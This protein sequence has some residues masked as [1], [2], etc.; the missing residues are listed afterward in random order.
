MKTKCK[1]PNLFDSRRLFPYP[2][3]FQSHT[4]MGVTVILGGKNQRNE[5]FDVGRRF[6]HL[7]SVGFLV[8]YPSFN[9]WLFLIG[10]DRPV[11][12]S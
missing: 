5:L 12:G 1:I 10:N 6:Y 2:F 9:T 11:H 8:G 3:E 4:T 7:E